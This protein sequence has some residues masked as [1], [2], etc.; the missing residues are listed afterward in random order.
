MNSLTAHWEVRN[1]FFFFFAI[2]FRT[3]PSNVTIG[4]YYRV[5]L[6]QCLGKKKPLDVTLDVKVTLDEEYYG[7]F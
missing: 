2:K 1:D 6:L 5:K 4:N 7:V 3:S